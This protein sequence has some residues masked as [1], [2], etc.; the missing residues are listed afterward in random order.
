MKIFIG[1][2][3]REKD[4]YD[5]CEYSI[6]ERASI[7][8]EIIPLIRGELISSGHYNRPID[9][10]GATEFTFT[11]F[12]VPKLSNFS[13]FSV[14]CDCDFLWNSDV[15]ELEALFDK[16]KAVQV[17]QHNYV[18]KEEYKMDGC[19]QHIYP[20]KNWSSMIVWNCEHPSNMVLTSDFVNSAAGSTLHQF[21][22]LRDG[23][24]GALDKTWNWLSGVY[25]KEATE[26]KVIHYTLG[27]PWF[28]EYKDVDWGELWD[29][30]FGKI[31]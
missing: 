11:R 8:V 19:K 7:D 30:E 4:A 18:P 27:G 29:K 20:R 14:F 13:G 25:E 23:E 28:E 26:P 1:Y 3:P 15:A 24:I 21:K 12:L 2:D 5:V 17:V 6:R 22:W 16:E 9:T 10:L 31:K